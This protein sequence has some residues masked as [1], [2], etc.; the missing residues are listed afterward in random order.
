[1]IFTA[2]WFKIIK[3]MFLKKWIEVFHFWTFKKCPFFKIDPDLFCMF[4]INIH[5]KTIYSKYI[6]FLCSHI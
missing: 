1:M 3:I 6:D 5:S 2:F 4:C